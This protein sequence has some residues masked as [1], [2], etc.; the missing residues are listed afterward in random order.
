MFWAM[1]AF[2]GQQTREPR[3]IPGRLMAALAI[4]TSVIFITY[5]QATLTTAMTVAQ[6]R[7]GIQGPGD[8]PGKKV[9]TTT[10]STTADWLRTHSVKPT[11]FQKIDDAFAALERG[12]LD[13]VVFD[14][15]VLLYYA[16][17]GGKGK[18][19]VVGEIFKKENY[20]ILFPQGSPL[21]KPVNEALLK[22][23]ESGAY[24][25][26]YEEWFHAAR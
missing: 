1:S 12:D 21:R 16:S 18:V 26:L 22:M 6:L 10:G 9:G 17:N 5:V 20:A 25:K 14:A 11:E 8:L 13:A 15:P 3:S 23:R 7:G 2:V 4:V 24:D 19:E